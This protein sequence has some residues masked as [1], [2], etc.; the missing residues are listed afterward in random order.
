MKRCMIVLGIALLLASGAKGFAAD[1]PLSAVQMDIEYA[2]V[3]GVSLKLDAFVPEGPGPFP[4]CI[5]VHGGGFTKGD[6]QSYIKPLF[7]S[8]SKAGFAWFTINYRLAPQHRWPAC[9]EDV[10]TAIRWVKD[11]ARE[12]NIDVNRIALIGESAGGFLV[13]YV[14]ARP[15]D[16][17]R[18]AA[19]VPFY[20]AHDREF[21]I[22]HFQILGGST[23]ALL[24]LTELNDAA[25][26]RLRETSSTTYLHQGMPPFLLIHGDQD[27][28]VPLEQSARFQEKMKALGNTCDLIIIPGGG[29]GMGGWSKLNSNYR[30]QMI[31][32]LNKVLPERAN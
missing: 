4:A 8:L 18:V 2:R 11:H 10:E 23:K 32:W 6:K 7:E 31:A 19:V 12:Y 15:A 28:Q 13:S 16:G 29:H 24:G 3:D 20:G 22:R 30:E 5:L 17:T 27:P 14:A 25:W 21:Q 26:Q 9:V 1:P